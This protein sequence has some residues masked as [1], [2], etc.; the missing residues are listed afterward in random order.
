[1]TAADKETMRSAVGR[2]SPT[3]LHTWWERPLWV[4]NSESERLIKMLTDDCFPQLRPAVW[5]FGQLERVWYDVSRYADD[6]TDDDT[7][8]ET[9]EKEPMDCA[10]PNCSIC[11][12]GEDDVVDDT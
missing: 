1:M 7:D 9:D 12:E 4:P 2:L 8:D 3:D 6:E 10:D 11:A 5:G